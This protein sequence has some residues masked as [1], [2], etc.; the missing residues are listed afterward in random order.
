MTCHLK[1]LFPWQWS[2]SH[3]HSHLNPQTPP[4]T[5]ATPA[6]PAI[7]ATQPTP[8]YP[9]DQPCTGRC[10]ACSGP[11]LGT[12]GSVGTVDCGP[13]SSCAKDIV[14]KTDG[15]A[16]GT[17]GEMAGWRNM[18]KYGK[19]VEHD[20]YI[21][22]TIWMGVQHLTCG[23]F[24][25][26]LE[27]QPILAYSETETSGASRRLCTQGWSCKGQRSRGWV[28]PLQPAESWKLLY[29]WAHCYKVVFMTPFWSFCHF[30]Y[31]KSIQ[32]PMRTQGIS[33]QITQGQVWFQLEAKS[34]KEIPS[35][36]ESH[37]EPMTDGFRWQGG[38][39]ESISGL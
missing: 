12:V 21:E 2:R 24:L 11:S 18:V 29:S 36:D 34:S 13:L 39:I 23:P 9:V 16:A 32:K 20:T 25:G 8:T 7:P 35:E 30:P 28:C 22:K 6:T 31:P 19:N 1:P 26:E 3:H 5:P 27:A 38:S 14:W 10:G 33:G 4:P 37:E 17:G 15:R